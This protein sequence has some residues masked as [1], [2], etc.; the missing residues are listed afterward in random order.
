MSQFPA[1][2]ALELCSYYGDP[3]PASSS[4]VKMESTL[5]ERA[6]SSP[7]ELI[8]THLCSSKKECK[9][10]KICTVN[11]EGVLSSHLPGLSKV[12][13]ELGRDVGHAYAHNGG[14]VEEESV[15]LPRGQRARGRVQGVDG[16]A[17]AA[18]LA[19][20]LKQLGGKENSYGIPAT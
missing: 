15:L 19:Y 5:E 11:F 17:P 12:A 3:L 10:K 2:K 13:A 8:H 18:L 16:T 14:L 20:L 7:L 9:H 1:K 4:H 6:A